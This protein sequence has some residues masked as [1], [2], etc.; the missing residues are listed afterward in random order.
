MNCSRPFKIGI[1]I[2]FDFALKN[3]EARRP[4]HGIMEIQRRKKPSRG[5]LSTFGD[6]EKPL[7]RPILRQRPEMLLVRKRL[8]RVFLVLRVFRLHP[9]SQPSPAVPFASRE[10]YLLGCF[11]FLG[12]AAQ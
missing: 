1:G 6:K 9:V 11:G 12:V 7:F 3:R 5:E 2:S 8:E 4:K 10:F